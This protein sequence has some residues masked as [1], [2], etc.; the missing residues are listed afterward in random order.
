MHPHHGIDYIEFSV[1]D[2]ARAKK[3][4]AQAFGWEFNDYGD[5]YAGIRGTAEQGE[6]EVGGFAKVDAVKTGG[7]LT[8]LYSRNLEESLAAVR[9]A[10]AKITREI[11]SF[12]GGKR[13]QFVDPFGNELGVW[14]ES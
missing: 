2:V 11:F 13:F 12:P 9:A 10:G 6:Q 8:V 7:V 14:S 3:F 4:Y 1:T 5:E